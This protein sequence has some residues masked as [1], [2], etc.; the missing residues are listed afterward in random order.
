MTTKEFSRSISQTARRVMKA[1]QF[2]YVD[3]EI[4]YGL[5]YISIGMNGCEFF[6]Q[7]DDASDIIAEAVSASNK[8]NLAVST[9][10]IWYLDNAGIFQK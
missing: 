8:T 5:P 2:R 7:G 3:I 6:A 1:K 10:L 4:N 9:C